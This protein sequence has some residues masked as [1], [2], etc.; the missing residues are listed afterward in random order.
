MEIPLNPEYHYHS[1][2]VC[3]VA[4]EQVSEQNPAM[5]L[6]CGHVICNE[7]LT[8]ISKGNGR[9]KCPYCPTDANKA[10]V[11]QIRF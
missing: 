10:S 4:K 6:P 7:S 9:F 3:P 2:F 11:R 5:F 8:K 1:V